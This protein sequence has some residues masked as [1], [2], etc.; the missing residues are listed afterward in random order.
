[1][2]VARFAFARAASIAPEQPNDGFAG[3]G[4][5]SLVVI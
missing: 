1:V 4:M 3:P 2:H 5:F